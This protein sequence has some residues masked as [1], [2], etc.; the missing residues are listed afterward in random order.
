MALWPHLDQAE[1]RKLYRFRGVLLEW[2]AVMCCGTKLLPSISNVKPMHVDIMLTS[3]LSTHARV[4]HRYIE[5]HA[6]ATAL[7]IT[8][9]ASRMWTARVVQST[10]RGISCHVRNYTTLTHTSTSRAIKCV[11]ITQTWEHVLSESSSSIT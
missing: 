8:A 1:F 11:C 2:Y 9:H 7:T 10:T 3:Y 6:C 4:T 5:H